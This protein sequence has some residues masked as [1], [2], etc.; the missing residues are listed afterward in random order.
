MCKDDFS[1]SVGEMMALQR[2]LYDQVGCRLGWSR[3]VKEQA[4][5]EMLFC[6]GEAGEVIDCLK[7]AGCHRLALPG[8]ER[9]H[10]LEETSDMLMVLMNML[11]CLDVTPEEL[12]SAYRAKHEKNL[13]RWC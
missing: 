11:L 10:L 4:N 3:H 2:K 13:H 12:S 5:N 7:K 8:P 6:L 1:L 9:D